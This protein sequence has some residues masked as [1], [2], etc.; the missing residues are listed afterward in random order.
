MTTLVIF[1]QN[2]PVAI[3]P[4]DVSTVAPNRGGDST[5]TIITTRSGKEHLIEQ[6]FEAV[7]K[8]LS[9][10]KAPDPD[11]SIRAAAPAQWKREREE[12]ERQLADWAKS[13]AAK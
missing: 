11:A 13:E 1:S 7:L 3:N 8:A 2:I 4:D 6:R 12:R 9:Q 10:E 5:W